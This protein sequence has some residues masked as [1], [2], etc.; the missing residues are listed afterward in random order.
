MQLPSAYR[1]HECQKQ[2]SYGQRVLEIEHGSFAPLV[3][4][5]QE[6]WGSV[7]PYHTRD[8]PLFYLS[9]KSIIDTNIAW[10]KCYLSVSLLRSSIMCLRRARSS[11]RRAFRFSVIDRTVAEAMHSFSFRFSFELFMI[12][13]PSYTE[14]VG[15]QNL[16]SPPSP[17]PPPPPPP[18]HTHTH[19]WGRGSFSKLVQL[20][21]RDMSPMCLI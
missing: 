9:S 8:L 13:L 5:H 17:L 19:F 11:Q 15:D 4:P 20:D 21:F 3:F 16:H 12:V 6:E 2:R 10:I 14:S 7:P 1:L 18:P